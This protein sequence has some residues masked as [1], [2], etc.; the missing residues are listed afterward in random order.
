MNNTAIIILAAGSSSRF[1]IA[2]QL[3]HFNNKTLLQHVIDEAIDSGAEP[4]I[5]ITG[6]NADEVSKEIKNKK[7]EIV[8]NENWKEGMASSIVA[9]VKKAITLNNN[10]EK[11]VIVPSYFINEIITKNV[12]PIEWKKINVTELL[13]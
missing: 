9:G 12:Y 6:A 2:K 5:V 11:I 10:I 4:I 1:G 3:L 7:I 8:F 13:K